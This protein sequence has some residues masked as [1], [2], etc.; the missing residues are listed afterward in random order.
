MQVM[1]LLLANYFVNRHFLGLPGL[2]S[3][4]SKASKNIFELC[5]SGIFKRHMFFLILTCS[6]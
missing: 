6:H 3:G 4:P 5:W 1:S 2:A